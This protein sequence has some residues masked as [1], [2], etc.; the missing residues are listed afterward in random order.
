M[1][2][3]VVVKQVLDEFFGVTDELDNDRPY[4]GQFMGLA[5]DE[6]DTEILAE[7]IAEALEKQPHENTN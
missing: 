5:V 7:A 3:K 2:T 4:D 6:V 1:N